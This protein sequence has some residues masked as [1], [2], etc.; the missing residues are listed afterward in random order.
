M[1]QWRAQRLLGQ[2]ES[3]RGLIVVNEPLG[4]I[5][6]S[7]GVELPSINLR[8][9]ESAHLTATNM[10]L[11][12]A[13]E[14]AADILSYST[15]C[16]QYASNLIYDL[17]VASDVLQKAIGAVNSGIKAMQVHFEQYP[18]M[19]VTVSEFLLTELRI[20]LAKGAD[21][22]TQI[23]NAD[24]I[25]ERLSDSSKKMIDADARL[26][27]MKQGQL[28]SPRM[29]ALKE[30]FHS[31]MRHRNGDVCRSIKNFSKNCWLSSALMILTMT[32][33]YDL[34]PTNFQNK[35]RSLRTH[36]GPLAEFEKTLVDIAPAPID[37]DT[38]QSPQT[39]RDFLEKA[40]LVMLREIGTVDLYLF[41]DKMIE[42]LIPDAKIK[43]KVDSGG[44]SI[45]L[46]AAYFLVANVSFRIYK[47]DSDEYYSV[48]LDGLRREKPDE[49][50][51]VVIT[52]K[53]SSL[54]ELRQEFVWVADLIHTRQG[55]GHVLTRLKCLSKDVV[56]CDPNKPL[57]NI[58]NHSNSKE[59][60]E[61]I[62]MF[63]HFTT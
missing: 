20:R 13:L 53:K 49:H 59:Q 8:T 30:M 17:G 19:Q 38:V 11:K 1:R 9:L 5:F 31:K 26:A 27:R 60:I 58:E 45:C 37:T 35:L 43:F 44:Y 21:F 4:Q 32:P 36:S 15:Y 46:I 33:L 52:D 34:F 57:C 61:Q 40:R 42:Y 29:I 25:Y 50:T 63:T 41:Y 54:H 28:G 14:M 48:S 7:Y 16:N 62:F 47:V 22:D 24:A 12:H 39:I 55:S 51:A 56:V 6:Q 23:R 3:Y 18:C 10:F 2:L